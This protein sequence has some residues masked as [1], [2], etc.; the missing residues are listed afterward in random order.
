MPGFVKCG[1][2][3]LVGGGEGVAVGI[4]CCGHRDKAILCDDLRGPQ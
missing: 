2:H 4:V 3:G 1:A